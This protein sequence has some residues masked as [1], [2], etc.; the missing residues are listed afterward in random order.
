MDPIYLHAKKINAKFISLV[1]LA[2][3]ES[4]DK[5]LRNEAKDIISR[6]PKTHTF[7][8]KNEENAI[9]ITWSKIA[10]DD[11]FSK[12]VGKTIAL[13]K[14]E[15][16]INNPPRTILSY[17]SYS[18]KV[19]GLKRVLHDSLPAAVASTF[20]WYLSRAVKY[21]KVDSFKKV[22]IE[23]SKEKNCEQRKRIALKM[24]VKDILKLENI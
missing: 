6:W 18:D 24:T 19:I 1:N 12:K 17:E 5:E 22:I 8:I 21:F 7:C 13:E 10:M 23:G 2:K 14:M 15:R 11:T 16:L 4:E 20:P 3:D 9:L